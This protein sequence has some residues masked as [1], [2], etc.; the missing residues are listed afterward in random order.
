VVNYG[1]DS[2]NGPPTITVGDSYQILRST[3]CLD[4]VGHGGGTLLSGSPA[5]PTGWVNQTLDPVYEF[6]DTITGG[7]T[8][9][10]TLYSAVRN[11]AANRDYYAQTVS[12]TGATGTGSGLLSARP[13]TCT[14]LV[15]YWAAD[16]NTLYQCSATNTWTV[17]YT[18]YTYPHPLT[19]GSGGGA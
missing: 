17:Y 8:V 2:A 1:Q 7:S 5:T 16:T 6:N 14:P 4:Q 11:L 15:A 19:Q 18:P 3:V 10:A 13:A 12:F 9:S